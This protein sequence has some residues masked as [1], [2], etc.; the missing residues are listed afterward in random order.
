MCVCVGC[1]LFTRLV[2]Q[3][4]W[5][6]DFR[7]GRGREECG[8]G[9]RDVAGMARCSGGLGVGEGVK[10]GVGGGEGGRGGGSGGG[11]G[12]ERYVFGCGG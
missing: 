4:G 10:G 12:G 1:G 2:V 8:G 5:I 7:R 11:G 9:F 6:R 3:L